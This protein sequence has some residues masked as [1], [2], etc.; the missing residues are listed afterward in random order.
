M[1]IEIVARPRIVL[2]SLKI[3]RPYEFTRRRTN[4]EGQEVPYTIETVIHDL[5]SV[6]GVKQCEPDSRSAAFHLTIRMVDGDTTYL[7]FRPGAYRRSDWGDGKS[8]SF[9]VAWDLLKACGYR[10]YYF[11]MK[12]IPR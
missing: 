11:L 8:S 9:A 7:S 12:D 2:Y 5:E 3:C 10:G 4:K 1:S 6:L